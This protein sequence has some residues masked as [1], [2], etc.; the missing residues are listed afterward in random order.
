MRITRYIFSLVISLFYM[1]AHGAIILDGKINEPDWKEAKKFN[2][3]RVVNPRTGVIAPLS[4]EA[5]FLTQE[6][7]IYV[8]FKNE[9]PP[10]TRR[11]S[12]SD[13]DRDTLAESN[14]FVID[15]NN[16]GDQAFAFTVSLGRGYIDGVY[17]IGSELN[18][19]WDGPWSF[20]VS[21]DEKYWYSEIFIPWKIATLAESDNSDRQFKVLFSRLNT[22]TSQTYST[23]YT[24][25][26]RNSFLR[27]LNTISVPNIYQSTGLDVA[28]YITTNFDGIKHKSTAKI[29]ADIFWKFTNNQQLIATVNPGFGAVESDDVVINYTSVEELLSDKRPF[30]TENQSLFDVQ[31]GDS[32]KMLY[33][34]RIGSGTDGEEQ[35]QA[36]I[37]FAGKY[38]FSGDNSDLGLLVAQEKDVTDV[39][40]KDFYSLRWKHRFEQG[41]IGQIVNYVERT[42]LE[43]T[44]LTSAIDFNMWQGNSQLNGMFIHANVTEQAQK[45]SA[46]AGFINVEHYIEPNWT[47]FSEFWYLPE[48]VDIDDFGYLE[49]NDLKRLSVGSEIEMILDKNRWLQDVSYSMEVTLSENFNG[50][51]LADD[52]SADI[53]FTLNNN[54]NF[55]AEIE[56]RQEGLYDDV[57][58]G[59]SAVLLP[60]QV[61]IYAEYSSPQ[62]DRF[63]YFIEAE[64]YK[65]STEGWTHNLGFY[66]K[67][68]VT[69]RWI[70][71]ASVYQERSKGWLIGSSEQYFE[72]FNAVNNIFKLSS[73]LLFSK[74]HQLTIKNQWSGI[75]AIGSKEYHVVN[76]LP[77][78]TQTTP[79]SFSESVLSMQLKYH[80]RFGEMSDFYLVYTRNGQ[81]FKEH[82]QLTPFSRQMSHPFKYPDNDQ[83]IAKLRWLW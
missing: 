83:I 51:E 49:R 7:G 47:V 75:K 79:E 66:T 56:Y 59:N 77:N 24:W 23:P 69:D 31:V 65:E 16:N 57:T 15:F 54:A 68:A 28:P 67:F 43:R 61:E 44:A 13:R 52:L 53:E 73:T 41:Y 29:G 34:R 30:F 63:R 8:A 74:R 82:K 71:K 62:S 5:F 76:Y 38:I 70:V 50:D 40:G 60:E 72:S 11:R 2:D 55:Y 27:D 46:N 26:D 25:D 81:Y 12:F 80:Y 42:T 22:S 64:R 33:T 21:E 37:G 9:Q 20:A 17:T 45:V 19:D 3:F 10:S 32:L 48:D 14:T 18:T 1:N 36:E 35:Q 6:N 4:T 78:V 58:W 39:D